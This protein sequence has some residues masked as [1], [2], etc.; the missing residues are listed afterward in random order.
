M[1]W[2]PLFCVYHGYITVFASVY[3]FKFSSQK[4]HYVFHFSCLETSQT[5]FIHSKVCE[6]VEIELAWAVP[7]QL[8]V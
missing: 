5:I 8:L 1:V 3:F 2:R 7:K 6:L 4:H